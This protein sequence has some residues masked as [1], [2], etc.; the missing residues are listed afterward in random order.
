VATPI[1][2]LSAARKACALPVLAGSGATATSVREVLSVANAVIVGSD[3]KHGGVWSNPLDPVRIETF[4]RA[5]K[6]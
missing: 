5:A 3:L 2:D 4:V 6:G 1:S